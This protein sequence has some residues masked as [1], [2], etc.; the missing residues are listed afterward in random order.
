MFSKQLLLALL[1]FAAARPT[2]HSE[3]LQSRAVSLDQY[4]TSQNQVSFKGAFAN[5]G[6]YGY[7]SVS[8]PLSFASSFDSCSWMCWIRRADNVFVSYT[9]LPVKVPRPESS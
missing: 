8:T 9:V 2:S 5:I 3:N 7:S 1:P 6:T 4:I